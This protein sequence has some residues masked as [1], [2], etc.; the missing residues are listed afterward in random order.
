MD[1]VFMD[2][3]DEDFFKEKEFDANSFIDGLGDIDEMTVL[4]LLEKV[5][6]LNVNDR[7]TVF[8]NEKLRAWLKEW[9]LFESAGN[10]WYYYRKMLKVISPVGLLSLYSVSEL[11]EFFSKKD[12]GSVSVFFNA[13][14][15][16]DVNKTIRY[17]LNDNEMLE[18][19]LE[20]CS[21]AY[22]EE[23][24]YDLVKSLILKIQNG[25][26]KF[27]NDFLADLSLECQQELIKEPEI[28]DD[29]LVC[30]LSSFRNS[31]KSDFF[32]NDTR[33]VYLYNRFDIVNLV[34]TGI[35]FN[36]NILK[37][38]DF[39][40]ALKCSSFI[41]FR[42][43]INDVE[44]NNNPVI[45]EERLEEYYDDLISRYDMESSL[46]KEYKIVLD[47]PK[48]Y[49]FDNNF[50]F[51]FDVV[52][53]ISS[54]LKEDSNGRFYYEDRDGLEALLES[55]TSK[56][57]SEVIIDA[58][59][60]DNI[61]NVWINI[62]EMLR[63]NAGLEEK[64]RVLDND[65]IDFYNMIL[66]FDKVGNGDKINLYNKLKRSNFSLIFYD[67]LRKV[68]DKAYDKIKDELI[69]PSLHPEYI[70]KEN[71]DKY[72]VLVYDLKDKE[73]TMLVRTQAEFREVDH[74]RRGCY[75]VIS[76]ENT[77]VFGEN[78]FMSFLYGYNSFDNDKVL[79][80]LEHDSFSSN[81]KDEG[82]R[83]VNRIM[84]TEELVKSNSGY[85]EVQLVNVKSDK[86]KYKWNAKKPDFIVVFDYIRDRHIEESKRLG[87]P[88]VVISRKVLD[89][90][91]NI[92]DMAETEAYVRDLYSEQEHRMKR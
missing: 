19:F 26:L 33:A 35:K 32:M 57:L 37:R 41:E 48:K 79:H 66:S 77:Q 64:D 92:Y 76:N 60:R 85:S 14:C 40:D 25:N 51:D 21:D 17:V 88:I 65:R 13:L 8:M 3:M 61:Y 5:M 68:K 72:G 80:M 49:G 18:Y 39:F 47:N 31:V 67:D 36:D 82:S 38:K 16:C 91:R 46:F 69:N 45:I 27:N 30:L 24:D 6:K 1:K 15:E 7:K 75:S 34:K 83:F 89:K 50:I 22:Y 12:S 73:Y 9:F 56:K 11:K 70:D 55:E 78:D 62:Q 20:H 44:K 42:S 29:T 90:D 28:S 81:L 84:S 52:E 71:T 23:L 4:E 2:F 63:Y 58:L 74:Y 54:H 43:R 53:I 87:I 86:G 10:Q 59:F